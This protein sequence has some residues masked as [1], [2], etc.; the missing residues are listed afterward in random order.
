LITA[1]VMSSNEFAKRAINVVPGQE[2]LFESMAAGTFAGF[3][4]SFVVGPVELVK[5]KMQ[6]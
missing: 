3:V 5:C 4:N 6:M 1:I 2:T